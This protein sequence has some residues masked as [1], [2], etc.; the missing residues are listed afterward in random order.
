MRRMESHE[1]AAHWRINPMQETNMCTAILAGD[2]EHAQ[3]TNDDL[4]LVRAMRHGTHRG[5]PPPL[6][7]LL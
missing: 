3:H 7:R 2:H 1:R 5:S 6:F 4:T